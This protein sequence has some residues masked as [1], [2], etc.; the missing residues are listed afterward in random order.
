MRSLVGSPLPE[1]H[2]TARRRRASA[3]A[4]AALLAFLIGMGGTA[5]AAIS[6]VSDTTK[7]KK[8]TAAP[9]SVMP[10]VLESDQYVYA[11]DER[12]NIGVPAAAGQ[13][14]GVLVSNL[15]PG[16]A[17]IASDAAANDTYAG[18]LA[19]GACVSSHFIHADSKA[20]GGTLF[21]GAVTFD[22]AIVAVQ[23]VTG[24]LNTTNDSLG[25]DATYPSLGTRG[26][27]LDAEAD[28]FTI[29]KDRRTIGFDLT[30][31]DSVDQLRVLTRG[32]CPS[33]SLRVTVTPQPAMLPN[34][35]G[36]VAYQVEAVNTSKTDV[37]PLS[38]TSLKDSV[39][40]DV[41]AADNPKLVSTT[42]QVPQLIQNGSTYTCAFTVS[43]QDAPGTSYE[44]TVTARATDADGIIAASSGAASVSLAKVAGSISGKALDQASQPVPNVCTYATLVDGSGP[45]VEARTNAQ[46]QY[47]ISELPPGSYRVWFTECPDGRSDRFDLQFYNG[48]A[49]ADE[50]T[51][52]AVEDAQTTP[53]IDA[54]LSILGSVTGRVTTAWGRPVHGATVSLVKADGS[55]LPAAGTQPDGT[56]RFDRVPAGDYRVSFDGSHLGYDVRWHP[57]AT[58]ADDATAVSVASRLTTPNINGTLHFGEGYGGVSGLVTDLSGAPMEN[59]NVSVYPDDADWT[60]YN[61]ATDADGKYEIPALAGTYE[62]RFTDPYGH[63]DG[64]WYQGSADRAGATPV[65]VTDASLFADVDATMSGSQY[66][67]ITGRI[68][69]DRSGLG[70]KDACVAFFNAEGSYAHAVASRADGRYVFPHV[71]PGS[72]KLYVHD[73]HAVSGG[74]YLAEWLN[75]KGSLEAADPVNVTADRTTVADAALDP[76]SAV[77]GTVSDMTGAPVS[78]VGVYLQGPNDA[79]YAATKAD[80]TYTMTG[81]RAGSYTTYFAAPYPHRSEY[82]NDAAAGDDADPVVVNG[83]ADVPN[84]NAQLRRWAA[85]TGRVVDG[86][87]EPV[88]DTFVQLVDG[89]GQPLQGSWTDNQGKYTIQSVEPGTYTAVFG[90]CWWNTYGCPLD[91]LGRPLHETEFW[92]GQRRREHA[93]TFTLG[94]GAVRTGLD[95]TLRPATYGSVEGVV[96]NTNDAAIQDIC[97]QLIGDEERWANQ[98][99]WTGGP[100]TDNA[101]TGAGGLYRFD[102]VPSGEYSLRFT[103]CQGLGYT[104]EWFDGQYDHQ[105]AD[106]V[107]VTGSPV[108]LQPAVLEFDAF[109]TIAGTVTNTAGNPV[110]NL[111]VRAVDS[112]TDSHTTTSSTV[113]E[114]DGSYT[115]T[116]VATGGHRV[117]FS[118]CHNGQA[119][120]RT[121]WW[122][123]ATSFAMAKTIVV[124]AGSAITGINATVESSDVGSISGTVTNAAGTPMKDM[125]VS[126]YSPTSGDYGDSFTTAGGMYTI[127]SLLI[128]ADYRVYFSDCSGSGYVAQYYNAAATYEAATPVDVLLNENHGGVNATMILGGRITGRVTNSDGDG[129][130]DICVNLFNVDGPSTGHSLHTQADGTYEMSGMTPGTYQVRFSDCWRGSPLHATR[131][132]NQ[133]AARAGAEPVTV[134]DGAPTTGV[135]AVLPARV[136]GSMSGTVS[137]PTGGLSG[138][139]VDIY[140]SETHEWVKNAKSASGGSYQAQDL[141][142]G[143]YK[144]LFSDCVGGQH[145]AEWFDD[146]AGWDDAQAVIVTAD[147]NTPSISA[148]LQPLNTD[149]Q[150]PTWPQDASLTVSEETS[151]SVK[152]TWTPATDN[153][154]VT[155]Y[156]IHVGDAV[157][158]HVGAEALDA[159]INGLSPSTQYT[160]R[161]EAVDAAN[162]ASTTGPTVQGTTLAATDTAKPVWPT[163]KSL[164]VSDPTVTTL[165]L[166]WSAATDNVSVTGYNVYSVISGDRFLEET[167]PAGTRTLTVTNLPP[168]GTYEFVVEAIDAAGNESVDGPTGSGST[169]ADVT[170]PTWPANKTLTFTNISATQL[171]LS[172][173]AASDDVGVASFTIYRRNDAG[174]WVQIG[175]RAAHLSRSFTDTNAGSGLESGRLYTY[176][177][178]A[179]DSATNSSTDGPQGSVRTTDVVKPTWP[180]PKSLTATDVTETGLTLSWSEASD[181]VGVT[182][183]RVFKGAVQIGST[184]AATRTFAVSGLVAWTNYEFRV[185]AIDDAANLSDTGPTTSA[186]TADTTK[187]TWPEPKTL[188]DSNNTETGLTLTW[189]VASDNVGVTA[190]R[191]Y[192]AGVLIDSVTTTTMNVTGL[193]PGSTYGF[194]V[195]AVDAAGN[196]S[197]TGP[198]ATASTTDVTKPTWPP[199]KSLTASVVTESGLTLSW[200]EATDNV[201]VT[202]YRVFRGATQIATTNSATRTLA[203]SGL[204]AWTLY[205]FRVEAVDAAENVSIDGPTLSQR[206]ADT[207]K[208]TWPSTKHLTAEN[209]T[210]TS[211]TLRWTDAADNV[212]VTGFRIYQGATEIGTAAASDRTFS[213][214]EL[215]P[216]TLYQFRVEAVDAATNISDAGPTL[217]ASTRDTIAP[218]WPVGSALSVTQPTATSVRLDWTAATDNV[219][220]SWYRVYA[221]IGGERFFEKAVSSASTHTSIIGLSPQTEYQFV[222]EALDSSDN[223]T[224]NGPSGV[225]T[226][227]PDTTAP[228][229]P[230]SKALTF[231]SVTTSS[232]TLSWTAATDDVGVASYVVYR[233]NAA[234]EWVPIGTRV[235]SNR[236]F[237]DSGDDGQG[238]SQGTVYAYKV[239]A[240]DA[241]GN[242]SPGT[243]PTGGTTTLDNVAP[244]WP[245]SKSLTASDVGETGMTLNWSEATDNVAVTNYRVFRNGQLLGQT[246]ASNR[247]WAVTGLAAGTS[248][249]FSVQALDRAANA[250]T[251]GPTRVQAT[252]D[253]TKPAWPG[254]TTTDFTVTE[255]SIT[256]TWSAA[257]DNVAVTDYRLYR[258]G[259]MVG[260]TSA[261]TRSFTFSGL[262]PWTMYGVRVQAIDASGNESTTGPLLSIRTTDSTKPVWTVP[263][264]LTVSN[265]KPTTLT[266]DW[267]AATDNVGIHEYRIFRGTTQIGTTSAT[268]RTFAVTGLTAGTAYTFSV[269]AVDKGGNVTTD[270]PTANATTPVPDDV[271][272]TWPT[273][274]NLTTERLESGL[275][276]L[277]WTAATDNVGV[278]GYRVFLGDTKIGETTPNIRV[279]DVDNLQ[280]GSTYNF[281]VEAFDAIGNLSTTGPTRSLTIAAPVEVQPGDTV[282]VEVETLPVGPV[283]ITLGNV[284]STGTVETQQVE[285]A[286]GGSTTTSV[287]LLP[288]SFDVHVANAEFQTAT[289]CFT[290]D[291]A[292]VKAA[293]LTERNLR[294]YHFAPD[295]A[296]P[297][298][299]KIPVDITSPG[300]PNLTTKQICGI[301]DSFSPFAIGVDAIAPNAVS[302]LAAASTVGRATLTWKNP[303]DEDLAT[304]EVRMLQGTTAPTASTGSVVCPSAQLR[305]S[306]SVTGLSAGKSYALSVFATDRNANQSTGTSIVLRGTALAPPAAKPATLTYGART[307]ISGALKVGG[308]TAGVAGRT[309]TLHVQ[310]QKPDR[311]YGAWSAAVGRASTGAGGAYSI[312]HKTLRNARYQV[313]FAGSGPDLGAVSGTR[314]VAVAP[315]VTATLSSTSIRLGKTAT[316]SGLVAPRLAGRT[317]ILQLRRSTGTWGNVAKVKLT[318]TSTFRFAVKPAKK[319][320]YIYRVLLPA[321]APYGLS[322]SP[323]RTLKVT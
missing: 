39:A 99:W 167:T 302:G 261:A 108:T 86:A 50:A 41:T 215:Q 205:E 231:S 143:T 313:R 222:V 321:V 85:V 173:P 199:S 319:G 247:T 276:R 76:G 217:E 35:G 13:R 191:V 8:L 52:V 240:R 34:S 307:A 296:N 110:P 40:G 125:C 252:I 158:F 114:P 186:R 258:D 279:I 292:Q 237:T 7:V 203:V 210:G 161:V 148:T 145:H 197:D 106:R 69:D 72:Y 46:G 305:T 181:N 221:V 283:S 37:E 220:L 1:Q 273:T 271:A 87:G 90:G 63:T 267:S 172:W 120:Y 165:K 65:V 251:D 294:L 81:V 156:R 306:C 139:C 169:L 133:S 97:V 312:P 300:Y 14:A 174:E 290:Y 126:A 16:A 235:A 309:V 25:A 297:T 316:V 123:E 284:T 20:T 118:T 129:I 11:F 182:G 4:F 107:K 3:A 224:T 260:S 149:T 58:T 23:S 57:N 102:S 241:A 229:W 299:P 101:Q 268:T 323:R 163:G 155:G 162:N 27:E 201:G 286:P 142:P 198:S 264:S 92:D 82:F 28:S 233:R 88:S 214:I 15:P 78:S 128:A 166:S 53:N 178:E 103:D 141:E 146:A 79:Y 33:P 68:T 160:F 295:P 135:N 270:G 74:R 127:D 285:G 228:T 322:T 242:E 157:Q 98:F 278:T 314:S 232:V 6:A 170:A 212:G 66:G 275:L 164:T 113:T 147:A 115:L 138:A 56:Y 117:E 29:S 259:A 130:S 119:N 303:T 36:P 246:T 243:G 62:V 176:K 83:L 289:V 49:G 159:T 190:Y 207:S 109:G 93:D 18:T 22:A 42:C 111:C 225:G 134:V 188:T 51:Q 248:Y 204:T 280:G 281:R 168:A 112:S 61:T 255:T 282:T 250:S 239:E 24:D 266:L 67:G 202:G 45:W 21:T 19:R 43:V 94:D 293:G 80:G 196:E 104:D 256:L 54:S 219:S 193:A 131:W 70:V 144:V 288:T 124:N 151:S 77:S 2:P 223:E 187:P 257:I 189:S 32:T 38:L 317:V 298:G 315:R 269:Q 254:A 195:Q 277:A 244:T 48:V 192:R 150:A 75:D 154:A 59:I 311:T 122:Q 71:L 272:P 226:T 73:C 47:T 89:Q 64:Q 234:L 12:Q 310:Y 213:V 208:P 291:P 185:E 238:L 136:T 137:T 44:S 227:L 287:K 301:T 211:L 177:V 180:L 60:S 121:Q 308:S 200:T 26:I 262:T 183:Y 17:E 253:V 249:T 206:T 216:A 153:V 31:Y 132:F 245:A 175:S 84:I 105:A 179:H 116:Q 318:A 265:V 171:T 184:N 5:H 140:N 274:K 100:Y 95:A 194:T 263:A 209:I 10:G 230:S 218:T 30:V 55:T 320:S 91:E 304:L 236:T 152:L 9:P 96:K